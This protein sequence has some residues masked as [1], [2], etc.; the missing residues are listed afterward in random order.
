MNTIKTLIA[1]AIAL[2]AV[3]AHAY[4]WSITGGAYSAQ[5]G[6]QHETFDSLATDSH[7]ALDIAFTGGQLFNASASGVTARPPGSVGQF[8]SVGTSGDQTGPITM[9]LTSMPASYY[10]FLWGS[11][12]AYNDVAFF[13][14]ASLLARLSGTDAFGAA[15]ANGFQG[16][17]QGGQYFNF[18]AGAGHQITSVVFRSAG[19]AFETDNHATIAAVPEPQT[20]AML[21]GGLG[22]VGFVARRRRQR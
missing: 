2:G 17:V 3:Q 20:Y 10:G 15:R 4:T 21:L 18:F 6:A 13:D 19:N 14:G 16:A 9:N 8:L 12:D 11:P 7:E 5:G 22:V 1:A